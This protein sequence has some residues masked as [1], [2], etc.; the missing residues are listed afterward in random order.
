MQVFENCIQKI[1]AKQYIQVWD[2][3]F[4]GLQNKKLYL[5]TL[6]KQSLIYTYSLPFMLSHVKYI[7]TKNDVV[8]LKCFN[9]TYLDLILLFHLILTHISW[10]QLRKGGLH[11]ILSDNSN[12]NFDVKVERCEFVGFVND[13]IDY[14]CLGYIFFFRIKE[15]ETNTFYINFYSI[16]FL[17]SCFF[18]FISHYF[19]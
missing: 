14:G 19:N 11:F 5:N 8:Y 13:V 16:I 7:Q 10:L 12:Y 17:Q 4:Y 9:N 1:L 3:P 15:K 18:N 2:S 6:I